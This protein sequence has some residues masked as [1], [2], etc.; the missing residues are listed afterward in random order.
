[1]ETVKHTV[2]GTEL[3]WKRCGGQDGGPAS[4]TSPWCPKCEVFPPKEEMSTPG[5]H[6]AV[7]RGAP[8]N[9]RGSVGYGFAVVPMMEALHESA[10]RGG[11]A[12]ALA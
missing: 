6:V 12:Q 9:V 10:H 4:H 8:T 2:C 7:R 1:M 5:P 11:A 3:I